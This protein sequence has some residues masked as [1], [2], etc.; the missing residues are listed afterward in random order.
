[1]ATPHAGSIHPGKSPQRT[2]LIIDLECPARNTFSIQT[3]APRS[4]LHLVPGE[5]DNEDLPF[6]PPHHPDKLYV[7]Q[8]MSR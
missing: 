3:A 1:M 8:L 7:I 4:N 6:W 5:P 2:H